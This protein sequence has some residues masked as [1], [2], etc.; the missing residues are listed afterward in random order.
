MKKTP[1]IAAIGVVSCGLLALAIGFAPVQAENSATSSKPALTADAAKAAPA[2]AA[3]ASDA[4]ALKARVD[5]LLALPKAERLA[6]FKQMPQQERRE[7]WFEMKRTQA[8][9]GGQQPLKR[10]TGLQGH[11]RSPGPRTP[12]QQ[13]VGAI[14]YD[15]NVPM[16]TFGGGAIIG[17]RFNTAVG[18][19][20]LVSGTVATVQAVVVQGPAFTTSSAGFVLEGPQ[21]VGG[22]AFAIFSSFTGATGVTD[23][24]TFTGIGAGYTGSSFL[25]LFGDFANSYV[26]A[27]GTGTNLGQGHHGI[28]GYTG[29]MGPNI[30][31]TFD[32]GG[33]RN[34]LVRATGNI[35]PVEL[36]SFDVK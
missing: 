30:T 16:T 33:T 29:G 27:F 12:R 32:F 20:V 5:A 23:T 34:G 2:Q 15:D 14:V 6:Q 10:G 25:V 7:L 35:L 19:P 8:T 3:T 21:T 9:Q 1:A 24:V 4:K 22:S 17:N 11:Q 36:L 28:V 26:P 31:S 18:N 13:A